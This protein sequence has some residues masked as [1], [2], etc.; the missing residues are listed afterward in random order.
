M[1]TY[2]EQGLHGA[3]PGDFAWLTG[4]WHARVGHDDVEEHWTA[5]GGNTLVATF[6]WVRDGKVLFYEIEV[7]EED[8]GLVYLRVKHFDQKLVGWEEKGAPHEFLLV[9]LNEHGAVFRELDKPDPRWAVYRRH[10]A[11]KLLAYFTHDMEPDP[12]PGVFK[13]ERRKP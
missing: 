8:A 4:S 12:Q 11:D 3:S 13:F 7:L 10:G 1:S 6:R 9:E 2:P 5:L